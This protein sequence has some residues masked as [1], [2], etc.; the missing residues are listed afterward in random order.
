MPI[1]HFAMI[2]HRYI[3][4]FTVVCVMQCMS[5]TLHGICDGRADTWSVLPVYGGGYVQNVVMAPSDTNVWYAY[6]DVGGPYRSDDAGK[7]WRALHGGFSIDDR[8]RNADH[9]RS[10]SV[11]PRDA[12]R[13]VIAGGN[14]GPDRQHLNT[15]EPF[16]LLLGIQQFLII[17]A[18]DH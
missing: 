10:L 8:E 5:Q 1:G 7:H 13:I 4:F 9:V 12:D 2:I 3:S 17:S 11:D 15:V 16:Q 6:V 18:C 14:I